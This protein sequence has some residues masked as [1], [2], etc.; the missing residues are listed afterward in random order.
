M[1]VRLDGAKLKELRGALTQREA[2]EGFR[3]EQG[4]LV[5]RGMGIGERT[6]RL[7]EAGKPISDVT[8]NLI[9]QYHGVPVGDL[10]I[11]RMPELTFCDGVDEKQEPLLEASFTV[12]EELFPD[13]AER[14]HPHDIRT[15]LR[16]AYKAADVEHW[17]ELWGA[18]HRD[19]EVVGIIYLSCHT[20]RSVCF[21]NY[22]GLRPGFPRKYEQ[23]KNFL[24]DEV[25]PYLRTHYNKVKAILFEV[26]SIEFSFL[27]EV[28]VR[29]RLAGHGDEARITLNVSRLDRLLFYNADEHVVAAVMNH[30]VPMPY[31][32]PAMQDP[33]DPINERELILMAYVFGC[34]P[35]ELS[36][37][38]ALDF[39][40]DD[41]YSNA[42]DGTGTIMIEGYRQYLAEARAR[43]TRD[44]ANSSFKKLSVPQKIGWLIPKAKR[45][46]L[47]E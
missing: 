9:A 17:R 15:W 25:I 8:A 10:I 37:A 7:A 27:R 3:N 26:E 18:F 2:A 43:L 46:K 28:A 14:D 16:E 34:L 35:A 13:E 36:V 38:E 41:L 32:Q 23:A 19:M 24:N 4:Q 45:E 47:L 20:E 40:F 21:G 5:K 6:L 31:F 11:E 22:F 30:G 39:L 1:L 33:L 44:L 29:K 42:Y 12:Y